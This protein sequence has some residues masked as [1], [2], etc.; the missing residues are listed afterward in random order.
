MISSPVSAAES[1]LP[2]LQG[3]PKQW[4]VNRGFRL[5]LTAL[6]SPTSATRRAYGAHKS[7]SQARKGSNAFYFTLAVEYQS[8]REYLLSPLSHRGLGLIGIGEY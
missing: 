3:L 8:V 7:V 6:R 1:P 5:H 2:P 4:H